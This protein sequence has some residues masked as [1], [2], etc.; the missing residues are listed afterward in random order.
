MIGAVVEKKDSEQTR[1][2][3]EKHGATIFGSGVFVLLGIM[4]VFMRFCG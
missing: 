1:G 3:A 4:V 2:W